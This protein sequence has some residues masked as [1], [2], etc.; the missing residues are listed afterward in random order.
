MFGIG[1]LEI[2]LIFTV[3]LIVLGP[4]RL[5]D[6]ARTIG[7][8][9]Y[10]LKDTVDSVQSEIEKEWDTQKTIKNQGQRAPRGEGPQR[11]ESIKDAGQ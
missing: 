2:I 5:P 6:A 1:L 4:N 11:E 8:W 7:T 10:K 9:F 3:A